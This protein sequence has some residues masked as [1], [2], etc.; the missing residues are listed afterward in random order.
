MRFFGFNKKAEEP[1]G[2]E[3][4]ILNSDVADTINK[5]YRAREYRN[6]FITDELED[7]LNSNE[8]YQEQQVIKETKI[9]YLWVSSM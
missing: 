3:Y 2:I 8:Y 6:K 4:Y 5:G 7:M 9:R 1:K